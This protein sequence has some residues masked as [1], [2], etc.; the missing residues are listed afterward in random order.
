MNVL[1]FDKLT[2]IFSPKGLPLKTKVTKPKVKK[3]NPNKPGCMPNPTS[4]TNGW[5]SNKYDKN[6]F[7]L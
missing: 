6:P 4:L 5:D 1:R 2:R 7:L 3:P